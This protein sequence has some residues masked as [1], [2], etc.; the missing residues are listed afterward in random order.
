M[1]AAP[2]SS[3]SRARAIARSAAQ[4]GIVFEQV[5]GE[6]QRLL[7]QIGGRR[8]IVRQHRHDVLGFQHRAD[9][10]ADRLPPVGGDDF[11]RDAEVVADELEQ[12]AQPHR[13]QRGP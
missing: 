7:A 2:L 11:D 6:P 4:V 10:I 12:L 1:S 13:V 5:G 9:A 3:S 8:R